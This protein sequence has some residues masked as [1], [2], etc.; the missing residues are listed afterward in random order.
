[1]R[2]VVCDIEANGLV[3]TKIWCIVAKDINTG[4]VYE[5]T[6]EE[7]ASSFNAFSKS[8]GTWVGHNFLSYDRKWLNR[9]LG[10]DIKVNQVVDTFILSMLFDANRERVRGIKGQHSLESWGARFGLQKPYHEDWSQYSDAMLQRCKT[11]VEI[12]H[13]VY[14]QLLREGKDFSEESIKLEHQVQ[15]L[16]DVQKDYG[17]YFNQ[18]EAHKLLAECESRSGSLRQEIQ[19]AFGKKAYYIR[20][21]IPKFKKDGSMSIVGLKHVGQGA[22]TIVS[23]TFN[24]NV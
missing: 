12:N 18:P 22:A 6:G 10:T 11:D 8:V 15:Y 23:K 20:Q 17:V 4:E 7:M 9:L 1:M 19:E 2:T 13:L 14:Q 16:L 3:P 5:F 21:V 24:L